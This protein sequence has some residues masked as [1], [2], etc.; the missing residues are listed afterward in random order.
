MLR[1]LS[2]KRRIW[3]YRSSRLRKRSMNGSSRLRLRT[4]KKRLVMPRK[5]PRLLR[6]P[7]SRD[8]RLPRILLPGSRSSRSHPAR[9]I[10]PSLLAVL[11]PRPP[12]LKLSKRS[13]LRPRLRTSRPKRRRMSPRRRPLRPSKRPSLLK[14]S[15][16]RKPKQSLR[17]RRAT[18]LLSKK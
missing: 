11:P 12:R 3:L 16:P 4:T 7:S 1:R 9:V 14:L 8:S 6:P 17:T 15:R 18:R 13:L 10:M 5:P 2:P